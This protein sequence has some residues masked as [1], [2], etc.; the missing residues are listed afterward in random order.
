MNDTAFTLT[1]LLQGDGVTWQQFN[2]AV[3]GIRKIELPLRFQWGF[4]YLDEG[5]TDEN[6]ERLRKAL[7]HNTG[8]SSDEA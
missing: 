7:A 8:T 4:V 2:D 6:I 5:A 1:A 3:G